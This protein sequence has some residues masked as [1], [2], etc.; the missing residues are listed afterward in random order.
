MRLLNISLHLSRH[1]CRAAKV[2]NNFS[3]NMSLIQSKSY[4]NGVWCDAISKQ[5]FEVINPANGTIVGVVP[6]MDEKDMVQ[7]I[8]SAY[9]AFYSAEWQNKSAK[10]R[11]QL[12]KVCI[13]NLCSFN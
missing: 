6:D 9:S 13:F 7:A 8:D 1:L 11:S 4:I 5:S 12:L 2:T 10:D 3:R